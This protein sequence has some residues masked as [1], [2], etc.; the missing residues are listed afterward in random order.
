MS[1]SQQKLLISILAALLGFALG[2]LKDFKD[3]RELFDD[4]TPANAV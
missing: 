4:P 2:W 1:E 3:R